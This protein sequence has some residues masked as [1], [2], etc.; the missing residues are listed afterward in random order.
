MNWF[1]SWIPSSFHN[2]TI[3][4]PSK[5]EYRVSETL[6]S[7]RN[8]LLVSRTLV[9]IVFDI[10]RTRIIGLESDEYKITIDP[11]WIIFLEI[12]LYRKDSYKLEPIFHSTRKMERSVIISGLCGGIICREL[13]VETGIRI[14]SKK[15]EKKRKKRKEQVGVYEDIESNKRGELQSSSLERD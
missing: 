6:P 13:F 12:S 15:K 1:L 5:R 7:G 10:K 11:R 14:N 2:V 8:N 4:I 3:L 9:N